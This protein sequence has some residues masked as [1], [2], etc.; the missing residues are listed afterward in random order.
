MQL[1]EAMGRSL[2]C[3][4]KLIG[5]LLGILLAQA[6]ACIAFP[7]N[8][9]AAQAVP[10]PGFGAVYIGRPM[11]M[12]TSL[13]AVP[14]ELDGKPFTSLGPGQYVV[15]ELKPGRH[16]VQAA[17]SF[18]SRAI[19]GRPHPAEVNVQAGKIYYLEPKH[20]EEN[21]HLNFIFVNG[22]AIP[23]KS[24]DRHSTFSVQ[25]SSPGT[26]PPP[27]FSKLTRVET[28]Q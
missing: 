5:G 10:R 11:T 21:P 19:N 27:N 18:W 28:H 23:E 17:D 15:I 6:V 16:V 2:Q 1:G 7:N 20:W 8:E 22:M 4:K 3:T 13:F 26:A 12:S 24:A 9:A 25:V 14:I